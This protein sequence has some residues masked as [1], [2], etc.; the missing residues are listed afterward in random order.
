MTN[1]PARYAAARHALA[2]ARSV[3]EVKDIRDKAIALATYAAQA[4]DRTM[5]E[6]ATEIRLRAEV[7]AGEMLAAAKAQGERDPGAG[8]DRRSRSQA[9]TVKLRDLGVTKSQSSCWQRLAALPKTEQED[10]IA[11]AKRKAVVKVTIGR[12]KSTHDDAIKR[13]IATVRAAVRRAMKVAPPEKLF[14]TLYAEIRALTG[15]H[16]FGATSAN[17]AAR[18]DAYIEE[19]LSKVRQ[20]DMTIAGLRKWNDDDRVVA[21]EK[22]PA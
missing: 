11:A 5:I 7:R 13:C 20:R 8:G 4:K 6:A 1:F 21:D 2:E 3:D 22:P 14:A 15:V 10:K 17:E 12:K 19:L 18:K 9:A 16:D